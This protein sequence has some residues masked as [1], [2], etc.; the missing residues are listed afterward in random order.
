P[1]Y[2]SNSCCS[3]PRAGESMTTAIRRRLDQE[4]GLTSDLRYLFKFRYQAGYGEA[5]AEHELCWVYI[6]ATRDPVRVNANEIAEWRFVPPGELDRE[7]TTCPDDF[8]PWFRQEWTRIRQ[9]H[10]EELA[11][12]QTVT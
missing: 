2:W 9:D 11:A 1:L 3:H 8:T 5:G 6:G 10:A 12:L 4:L 7:M